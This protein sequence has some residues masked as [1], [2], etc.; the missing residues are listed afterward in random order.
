M[1]VV[2][3]RFLVLGLLAVFCSAF[4]S[5]TPVLVSDANAKGFGVIE[6][7]SDNK[8]KED[9]GGATTSVGS[10]LKL[11]GSKCSG[12]KNPFFLIAC[13][14]TTTLADL[15]VLVYIISG[16][17]LIAFTFGAIFGK[18]SWK[19]LSQ[20]A[21]GLFLVAMMAP[22]IEYFTHDGSVRLKFGNYLPTNKDFV[23]YGGSNNNFNKQDCGNNCTEEV[24]QPG[25]EDSKEKVLQG[26]ESPNGNEE[27]GSG[28]TPLANN[29]NGNNE[30]VN[31][32]E[33]GNGQSEDKG[34]EKWSWKDIKGSAKSAMG[35]AK[36][37][38]SIINNAK[39]TAKELGNQRDKIKKAMNGNNGKLGGI[40][41]SAGDIINAGKHASESIYRMDKNIE[42]NTET[43]NKGIEGIGTGGGNRK[44][45]S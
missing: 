25:A 31:S 21:F 41:N 22:F 18:I 24:I 29:E 28:E 1:K 45:K 26:A 11:G 34:K 38:L 33:S 14:A 9:T 19:H 12:Q 20:L 43:I 2:I 16:F 23:S 13:K 40:I 37:G 7:A 8:S 42:A 35:A 10:G 44:T 6:D 3:R 32:E 36:A 4:M 30:N 17:G 5:M 15:R 27:G 39:V